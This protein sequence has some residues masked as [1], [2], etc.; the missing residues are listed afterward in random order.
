MHLIRGLQRF[1]H[2]PG[3]VATIGNFDGLHLGHQQL[4]NTTLAAASK[5]GVPSTII[6]FDPLPNEFFAGD[7]AP[8]RIHGFRDRYLTAAAMG[9]D[10]YLLLRFDQQLADQSPEEFI[11]SIFVSTIGL[12]HLVVGDDFRFGHKRKGDIA[13]LQQ[14]GLE[15]GFT[16]EQLSTVTT[17]GD[18]TRI[19]SSEIRAH[20]A[21]GRLD[22]A[23]AMLGRPYTISGR[24]IHGEKVGRQLGFATA[25]VALGSH[26]PPARGVFAV[27]ALH[28]ET[29]KRYPAVANLGERPT[30]GGRK[31]LLE[32]HCLDSEPS[33]YGQHLQVEFKQYLR[34]EQKFGSL[35]EL[36]QAIAAD[37]ES[38]KRCLG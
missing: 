32:V 7:N 38:A 36:K 12:K 17:S 11:D 16:V 27:Q 31:L 29:G 5:H 22:D 34:G 14:A 13:L 23:A 26:R 35:D 33:L 24:V 3:C 9:V 2:P 15:H 4:V 30:V 37:A 25:N 28:V 1:S 21:A 8:H 20:L 18:N 6:S 10:R 19:S